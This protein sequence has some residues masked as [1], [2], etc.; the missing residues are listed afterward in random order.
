MNTSIFTYNAAAPLRVLTIYYNI[1]YNIL[2]RP[3]VEDMERCL[4][5]L[6]IC[7]IYLMS[8]LKGLT[9]YPRLLFVITTNKEQS[10]H[11]IT[12]A[13]SRSGRDST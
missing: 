7:M 9:I 4:E 11:R 8:G 13:V 1:Y 12:G 2:P 3:I 10:H 5:N 6:I